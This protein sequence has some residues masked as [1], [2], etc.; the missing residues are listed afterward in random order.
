[1]PAP[2]VEAPMYRSTHFLLREGTWTI[3]GE[4]F[5]PSTADKHWHACVALI[6]HRQALACVAQ[7][8]ACAVQICEYYIHCSQC[9]CTANLYTTYKYM[10]ETLA[11]HDQSEHMHSQ[12][13]HTYHN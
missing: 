13:L 7:I 4:A 3:R 1:M 12:P 8:Y 11:M 2:T 6:Y 10:D 5:H 9:I